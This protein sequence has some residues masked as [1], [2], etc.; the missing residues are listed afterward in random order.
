MQTGI[1]PLA[2]STVIAPLARFPESLRMQALALATERRY[3]AGDVIYRQGDDDTYVHYL[4][5]GSV[6]LL[7]RGRVTRTV[8]A[9]RHGTR[10]PIDPGGRKRYTARA[11]KAARVLAFPRAALERLLDQHERDG[12]E[13]ALVVHDI[14][15]AGSSDW[16][17]RLLQSPLFAR[18][19]AAS[20]QE[21]F[22]RMQAHPVHADEVVIRQG[23]HGDRYYVVAQG[24]CEVAR[25]IAG[26]RGNVHLADL[27]PGASFGEEALI[28]GRPRNATVTMLSDGLLMSLER[29]DFE[30]LVLAPAVKPIDL[31]SACSQVATG[32]MW[33]D[34]R[35]PEEHDAR[36][37]RGSRNLPLHLLR[38]QSNRLRRDGRYV[39]CSDDREHAAVGA[40]LLVERGFD[41]VYL[42]TGIRAAIA[43]DPGLDSLVDDEPTRASIV[44]LAPTPPAATARSVTDRPAAP[45]DPLDNTLGHIADLYT[46]EE[47]KREMNRPI[48]TEP[49]A[50]TGGVLAELAEEIG[51]AHDALNPA[52]RKAAA[53]DAM[54]TEALGDE[55]DDGLQEDLCQT[56]DLGAAIS[57]DES[58]T[59][60]M[61]ETE[62]R[63]RA[64][65]ERAIAVRGHKL[66]RE[67]ELK[68]ARMRTMARRE[69][70]AREARTRNR[71]EQEYRHKEQLLRAN[72][73]K[74]LA[75][76]NALA[77][78]QQ[79]LRTAYQDLEDKLGAAARL[80]G[81]LAELSPLLDER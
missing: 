1:D 75:F 72:Y 31:D 10:D 5:D 20:I 59:A 36:C 64:E 57:I 78:R 12:G 48:V 60:L 13:D 81:E 46:F 14:A 54:G 19:P 32:A 35:Y 2:C 50:A 45:G 33:L 4:L 77:R 63:V 66:Q 52:A 69:L 40:F 41:A 39:V 55:L 6:E 47:A 18:L 27:G 34:V 79:A 37:I 70:A 17:V 38:L 61:A 71:L 74:L 76:A 3:A 80:Y 67:Y 65:L 16:R 68:L 26:G 42:D 8:R 43:Q 9:A 7:V 25:S 24:Y 15:G 44:Y 30:R 56:R 62:R 49:P 58:I 53:G 51:A 73:K 29:T 22:A 21:I 11:C 28:A 23:S